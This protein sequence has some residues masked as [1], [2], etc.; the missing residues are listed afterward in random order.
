[1]RLLNAWISNN[2]EPITIETV[3]R[4]T[5]KVTKRTTYQVRWTF[6]P[7]QGRIPKECKDSTTFI[8]KAQAKLFIKELWKAHHREGNWRFDAKGRPTDTLACDHTVL[9]ALDEYVDSRWKSVWKSKT[10]TRNVGRFIELVALTLANPKDRIKL[11]EALEVQRFDRGTPPEPANVVEW[12]ARWLRQDSYCERHH[13]T[14]SKRAEGKAW[15]EARSMQLTDLLDTAQIARLRAHFTDGRTYN[16]QRTYWKGSITPFL[17]WIYQTQKVPRS[18]LLGDPKLSRDL[19]AE[20]PD[21][22]R[23]PDPVQLT[24]LAKAM[25]KAKGE[26]WEIFVLVAGHCALRASEA[27]GLRLDAFSMEKG[28]L[29]VSITAQEHR[30]VAAHS[31]TGSTVERTVTKSK[32]GHTPPQ[33][34][35]PIPAWLAERLKDLYGAELGHSESYLFRGPRG[36]VGNYDTVRKWWHVAVATCYPVGHKLGDIQLHTLRHAGM[37][38]WLT[39]GYEH[40]RIQMWGGWISLVQM[41]DT[42]AGVIDSLELVELDKLDHFIERFEP[43]STE[44]EEVKVSQ[45]VVAPDSTVVVLSEFRARRQ[46]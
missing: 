41:L 5:G 31:D 7:L 36:A 21:P 33:R 37:T 3:N 12:A 20:R 29:W 24:R 13:P 23:I 32:K 16:T 39:A 35:V 1:M 18:P 27:L 22:T 38:Y 15:I 6:E 17:N 46:A 9:S 42:Y 45:D 8:T 19:G 14:D 11:M 10:R 40:R 4:K 44:P 2:G 43:V 26:T 28:R 30:T 25:G 34:R